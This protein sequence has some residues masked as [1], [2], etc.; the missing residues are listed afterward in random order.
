MMEAFLIGTISMCNAYVENLP[1]PTQDVS[2]HYDEATVFVGN[3]YRG[4]VN[5]Y[6]QPHLSNH[7][8]L[9]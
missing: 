2:H 7:D 6:A 1:P 3:L 5:A 9:S 4:R 8:G